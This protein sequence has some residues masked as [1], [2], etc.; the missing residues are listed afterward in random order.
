MLPH[1]SEA[2]F[3]NGLAIRLDGQ[4]VFGSCEFTISDPGITASRSSNVGQRDGGV[5]PAREHQCGNRFEFGEL[6]VCLSSEL[7]HL[8]HFPQ[9]DLRVAE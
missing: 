6:V 7:E 5:H 8:S 4:H 1:E 9:W 3:E 2:F